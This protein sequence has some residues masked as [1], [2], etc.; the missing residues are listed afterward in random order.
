MQNL[1]Q[2]NLPSFSSKI[3]WIQN[4][5][6]IWDII[7]KQ[8]V[9]LTPEEWVRQHFVHLLIS[10]LNYPK[11]LFRVES[12]L[13]YD[14]KRK[15]SDIQVLNAAGNVFLLIECKAPTIE[16]NH[17][18]LKQLSEY[19]KALEAQYLAITNGLKHFIWGYDKN[20]QEYRPL[21]DF[22]NYTVSKNSL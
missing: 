22:P 17:N 20:S 7:R 2:L 13:K 12:N 19:N 9:V 8:Y 11:G 5:R 3:E 10:H 18:T 1:P 4:N 14:K 21:T 16:L 6:C 15:R